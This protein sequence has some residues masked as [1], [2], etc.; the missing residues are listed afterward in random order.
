M[1]L[2]VVCMCMCTG[3]SNA[4]NIAAVVNMWV[5]AGSLHAYVDLQMIY[6]LYT[7][8]NFSCIAISDSS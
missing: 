4:S 8:M 1:D 7:P 2:N 5:S 6:P 3:F